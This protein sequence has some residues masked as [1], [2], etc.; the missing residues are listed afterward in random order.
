MADIE[1][2]YSGR[3]EKESLG[4]KGKGDME[5]RGEGP[6]QDMP[7]PVPYLWTGHGTKPLEA[8]LDT[9][10]WLCVC[11]FTILVWMASINP[12]P[13]KIFPS[14]KQANSGLAT[15]PCSFSLL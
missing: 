4:A 13:V 10:Q 3:R 6:G 14:L 7:S 12:K 11:T 1:D 8:A 5:P 2:L 15:R 9:L